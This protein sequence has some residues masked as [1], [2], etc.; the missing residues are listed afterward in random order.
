[1]YIFIYFKYV[2]IQVFVWSALVGGNGAYTLVQVAFNDLLMLGLYVPTAA[3]LIGVSNIQLPWETI[4]Y[5]VLLFIA[6]PLLIAATL[7]NVVIH[8][9]NI[10]ILNDIVDRFKPVTVICLLLTLILIFIFQGI[11]IELYINIQFIC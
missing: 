7:R 6:A 10:N 4:I 1:M 8:F 11:Y 9:Y 5:A 3:L 2:Y